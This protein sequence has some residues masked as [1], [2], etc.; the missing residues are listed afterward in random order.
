MRKTVRG[1]F[2]GTCIGKISN[3]E[4][5]FVYRKH[6][7]LL[8]VYVEDEIGRRKQIMALMWKKLMKRVDLDEPTS[9]LHHIFLECTQRECKPNEIIFDELTKMFES[10]FSAGATENL[11]RW[12]EP[13]EKTVAWS[14]DVEGHARKCVERRCELANKK[15]MQLYKDSSLCVD[16]HHFKKDHKFA[17]KLS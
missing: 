11:S 12:E 4:C 9:F 10:R 15:V 14:Y 8:S 2:I 3:E 7:L 16:D 1:R 5:L 6:A 17:H 13:H